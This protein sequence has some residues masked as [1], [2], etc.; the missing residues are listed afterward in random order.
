MNKIKT[1]F[2]T[3][4][5]ILIAIVFAFYGNTLKNKYALDDYIVTEKGNMTTQGIKAIPKII[6][7]YYVDRSEDIKFD[8]RPM[9][10]ISF[11]IEHELFY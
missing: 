6:K 1:Y 2:N 7:S 4:R 10:K 3:Q 9:V 5:I 11:A 8:Y